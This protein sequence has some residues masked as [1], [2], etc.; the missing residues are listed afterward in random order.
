MAHA[1]LERPRLTEEERRQRAVDALGLGEDV[2]EERFD[3]I[4]RVARTLLGARMS[5]ITVLDRDRACYPGAA[6]YDGTAMPREQTFCHTTTLQRS[7]L[8]V[9]DARADG[10]FR[11]LGLVAAGE[12]AFYAGVPLTDAQDN[13]V[14]VLCVFDP[15]PGTLEGDRLQSFLDLAVWAEQELLASTEMSAAARVQASLLPAHPLRLPD[16]EAAGVCLPA[17][18]VGGDFFDYGVSDGV[19]HLGLGDVMGKGT[20]AALVGAGVRAALRATHLDVVA[21]ADL[22]ASATAVA[23][24]LHRDLDRAGAFAAL[25]EAAVDLGTGEIRFVDAGLGLM[26]VVR[27]DGRVERHVGADRPFGLFADDDWTERRAALGPGDRLLVFTDGVLDLLEDPLH[28][29]VPVGELVAAHRDPESLL[30][31][32][33]ALTRGRTPLDDVTALAVYRAPCGDR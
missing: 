10:R 7:L 18:A 29:W 1:V 22:G 2:R 9:P 13:V 16:W 26:L 8:V 24:S 6:G 33:S 11:D 3:R 27:A 19:L 12:V 15:E 4:S 25:V 28:W 30:A 20:G 31:A 5:T 17:L 23:R 21:G 14:G 32:L